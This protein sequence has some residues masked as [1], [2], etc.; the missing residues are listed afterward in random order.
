M[1]REGRLFWAVVLA[2]WMPLTGCAP[3]RSYYFFEDGD[4]SHYKGMATDIEYPDVESAT[5]SEVTGAAPPP[6]PRNMEDYEIWNLTL[7]EAV[8][9]TL[10]NSK[11]VRLLR[12]GVSDGLITSPDQSP[13]IYDP[14]I[15]QSNPGIGQRQGAG[16][17]SALSAFDAQL[18]TSMFWQRNEQPRNVG[19]LVG[20]SIFA[21]EFLQDLATFQAELAK[22]TA[23]GARFSVS[24]QTIY[25]SNNNPTRD[26]ASDYNTQFQ[27]EA[28]QPVLQGAGT[29]FNRIAG[30]NFGPGNY[31]GVIIARINGDISLTDF[32]STVQT[33]VR[34]VEDTYWQLYAAYRD[35][36][37]ARSGRDAVLQ[38]WR[39]VNALAQVG[40]VGGGTLDEARARSEYLL[41]KGQAEDAL[42]RLYASENRLRYLMGL[43]ASDGRLIRPADE[44]STAKL[45]FEWHEIHSEAL[46]RQV[47]LRRQKWVIKRSEMQLIA[48]RNFLLPRLDAVARYRWRGLGDDL[49]DPNGMGISPNN[50]TI[51]GTD[52]FATL[53]DGNYQEW[54]LGFQ[55]SM[56][57]G[58]RRELAGVRNAQL[59]LARDRAVL[60]DE[61][62]EVSHLLTE[63]IRNMHFN[64][65][66]TETYYNRMLGAR[67]E[68]EAAQAVFEA[69]AELAQGAPALDRLLDAQRRLAVAEAEYYRNLVQYNQSITEV[70]FRKGS[71][72]EY[73]NIFLAEGPWPHKAYYDA[74]QRARERDAGLF[75]NYG[76]TRPSVISR[77]P[78]DQF[79]GGSVGFDSLNTPTPQPEQLPPPEGTEP[80][81]GQTPTQPPT[82]PSVRDP[83]PGP[84]FSTTEQNPPPAGTQNPPPA[85]A[86]T[87]QFRPASFGP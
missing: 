29:L 38:A 72:L 49:L 46:A 27:V 55:G 56:T 13:T 50:P 40:G 58:F 25:D 44:P 36:D 33:Q 21:R 63:A 17:E 68:V 15:A 78:V 64:Y 31:N 26:V 45:D 84:R 71:L 86:P 79:G 3:S 18:T 39:K 87:L 53:T 65:Q 51:R 24:H 8:Q 1:S 19:G 81:P 32:E 80:M 6:T 30:P 11:V 12:G 70:H 48:A 62:L 35:F 77:G 10:T 47:N 7:Q 57:L 75:L 60:Q 37:A 59:Q 28:R 85:G 22:Q 20:R 61:E 67:S 76:F 83:N 52:A 73:N 74:H 2:V 9:T 23:S 82:G 42:R 43:S 5:L 66:I 4:L 34:Q 54:E 69:G 14:A 41:F 16:V